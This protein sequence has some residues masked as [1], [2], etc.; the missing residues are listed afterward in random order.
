MD[1]E[2]PWRNNVFAQRPW[3]SVRYDRVYLR[4]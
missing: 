3:R 1:G 2:G 4:A